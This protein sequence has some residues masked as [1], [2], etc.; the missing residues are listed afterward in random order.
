[1]KTG[2][3]QRQVSSELPEAGHVFDRRSPELYGLFTMAGLTVIVN[4]RLNDPL[5]EDLIYTANPIFYGIY[6]CA[7]TALADGR[8][9][10]A[11]DLFVHVATRSR[12]MFLY[13]I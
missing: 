10:A 1:L 4:K 5:S 11:T 3:V 6:S 12:P 2:T 8:S 7:A 9:F 13:G